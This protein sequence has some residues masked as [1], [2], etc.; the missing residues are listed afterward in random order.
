MT[1]A[2]IIKDPRNGWQATS[3]FELSGCLPP[4]LITTLQLTIVTRKDMNGK[5]C[6]RASVWRLHPDGSQ[7]HCVGYGQSQGADF[8][9][10]IHTTC[11]AR[12]TAKVVN[13][14]H[15]QALQYLDKVK[16]LAFA[17]YKAHREPALSSEPAS[18]EGGQ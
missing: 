13:A 18:L 10:G 2:K 16:E 12:I 15:E 1:T 9:C 11:P 8:G 3:K 5:L 4:D 14:Q 6:S 7:S 17:F